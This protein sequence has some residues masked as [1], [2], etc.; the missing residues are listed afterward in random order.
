M[1]T[2]AKCGKD[3]KAFGVIDPSTGQGT[4]EPCMSGASVS[5]SAPAAVPPP[6]AP[7]PIEKKS[8]VE[9]VTDAVRSVATKIKKVVKKDDKTKRR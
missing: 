8:V 6:K 2:C 5:T 7:S 3:V 1:A 4:C 9:K